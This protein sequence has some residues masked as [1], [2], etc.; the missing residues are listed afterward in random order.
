MV[1]NER[2]FGTKNDTAANLKLHGEAVHE[3]TF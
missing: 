1:N 2:N 3:N